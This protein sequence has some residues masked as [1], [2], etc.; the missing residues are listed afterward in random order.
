M[1]PSKIPTNSEE[2]KRLLQSFFDLPSKEK[3]MFYSALEHLRW[4]THTLGPGGTRGGLHAQHSR[5]TTYP[6]GL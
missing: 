4:L 6:S 5:K 1:V 3:K 2:R